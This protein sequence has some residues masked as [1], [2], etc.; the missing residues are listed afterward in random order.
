MIDFLTFRSLESDENSFSVQ[1]HRDHFFYI[2]YVK[3]IYVYGPQHSMNCGSFV[4][5]RFSGHTT[6]VTTFIRA[7]PL[8]MLGDHLS[9]PSRSLKAT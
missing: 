7:P 8:K 3:H 9:G 1:R 5:S 4:G 6:V 2:A